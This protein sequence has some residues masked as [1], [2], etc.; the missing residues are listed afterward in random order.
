MAEPE[1][2]PECP[3]I[4]CGAIPQFGGPDLKCRGG[5]D[6]GRGA[7]PEGA[8]VVGPAMIWIALDVPRDE[9]YRDDHFTSPRDRP[10]RRMPTLLQI[11]QHWD[12]SDVPA[13]CFRCGWEMRVSQWAP[14]SGL[15]R[16]HIIPRCF[17]GTDLACNLY[18]LCRACHRAQPDYFGWELDKA[19]G[20]LHA[21]WGDP[22]NLAEMRRR[23]S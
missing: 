7:G 12:V 11:A 3:V 14:A 5:A 4:A 2:G 18:P 16:A 23:L 1:H 21:V 19:L 9:Q 6:P 22:R 20:W 15:E 13:F 17:S 8:P 10:S